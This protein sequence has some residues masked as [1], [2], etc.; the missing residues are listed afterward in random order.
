[1]SR[2]TGIKVPALAQELGSRGRRL[3]EGRH[4]QNF[5]SS[6]VGSGWGR[7]SGGRGPAW[8][9]KPEVGQQGRQSS[10]GRNYGSRSSS[11]QGLT[12]LGGDRSQAAA[13]RRED[14]CPLLR[15][16]GSASPGKSFSSWSPCILL[17]LLYFSSELLPLTCSVTTVCLAPRTL[18]T[19]K[20]RPLFLYSAVCNRDL[21]LRRCPGGILRAEINE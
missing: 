3:S 17:T 20:A 4:E 7:V 5:Q 16:A 9:L 13:D 14:V 15:D 8:R 12:L 18:S 1:M 6:V 10:W 11:T 19:T 21:G 2:S